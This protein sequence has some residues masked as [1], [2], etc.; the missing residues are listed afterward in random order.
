VGKDFKGVPP[1]GN[2]IIN[3]ACFGPWI[4]ITEFADQKIFNI[5]NNFVT[6]DKTNL[7]SPSSGFLIPPNSP[8]WKM[9]F[10]PIPFKEIGL[11]SPRFK[12]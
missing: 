12:K 2:S 4:E 6:S 11:F 9:G 5:E 3:N 7:G 1:E 8:V 10:K